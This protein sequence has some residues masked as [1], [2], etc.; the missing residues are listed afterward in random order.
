MYFTVHLFCLWLSFCCA[1]FSALSSFA[2]ILLWKK[3]GCFAL[4]DL[5]ELHTKHH[6]NESSESVG[7]FDLTIALTI[8]HLTLTNTLTK[9]FCV[10]IAEKLSR[11]TLTYNLNHE[12]NNKLG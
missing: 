11:E 1:V 10:L 2:S 6:S 4:I 8:V 5:S 7:P 9:N 3:T 12:L